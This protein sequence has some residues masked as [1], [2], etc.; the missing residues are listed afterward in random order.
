[1]FYF[2]F[3]LFPQVISIYMGITINLVDKWEP[4]RAARTALNN[5]LQPG[6][7]QAQVSSVGVAMG[8]VY[9]K[10]FVGAEVYFKSTK[11]QQSS[12]IMNNYV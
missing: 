4:Y 8:V 3:T 7:I 11:A 1:M 9:N 5:T 6:N 12:E 2:I 10:N